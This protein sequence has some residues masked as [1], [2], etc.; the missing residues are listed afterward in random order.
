MYPLFAVFLC[1][2]CA[3]CLKLQLTSYHAVLLWHVW[4]L[5]ASLALLLPEILTYRPCNVTVMYRVIH[6]PYTLHQ[7]MI[8]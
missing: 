6:L 8:F 1:E 5:L 2:T 7:Y 4:S 3:D